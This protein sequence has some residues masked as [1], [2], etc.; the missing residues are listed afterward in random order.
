MEDMAAPA[1]PQGLITPHIVLGSFTDTVFKPDPYIPEIRYLSFG[2]DS[3]TED[4]LIAITKEIRVHALGVYLKRKDSGKMTHI[5]GRL[6]S[7]LDG[8]TVYVAVEPAGS[9]LDGGAGGRRRRRRRSQSRRSRSR[10][11]RSRR[12]RYN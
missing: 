1:A 12:S 10:R 5:S 8:F 9:L 6:R 4:L 2:P 7:F 11:S 3:T